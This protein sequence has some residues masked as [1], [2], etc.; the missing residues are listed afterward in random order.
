MRGLDI[1]AKYAHARIAV[2]VLGAGKELLSEILWDAEALG[3]YDYESDRWLDL[4]AMFKGEP[5]LASA[6]LTGWRDQAEMAEMAEMADCPNCHDGSGNP[7]HIH[8]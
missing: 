5:D 6:W 2:E 7:C 3:R 1:R 4:P 8:G